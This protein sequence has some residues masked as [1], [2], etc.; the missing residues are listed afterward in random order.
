MNIA[1]VTGASSGMGREF[2]LQLP[3]Y[4]AVDEIWVIARR[5][6]AL[7]ALKRESILPLRILALD[8]LEEEKIISRIQGSGTRVSLDYGVRR[9]NMDIITIV[10]PAQN[11]FFAKMM[12][13]VQTKADQMD[14]L[15]LFQQKPKDIPLKAGIFGAEPWTE[16]M[17]RGIE[18]TLSI[19]WKL[20]SILPRSELKRIKDEYLDMHYGK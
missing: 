15:V 3:A 20:L 1:V 19:G 9:G 10:A 18:E 12:D 4:T 13:A 11:A 17:R 5:E 7:E 16:E 8:L 14:S 6:S 2:V